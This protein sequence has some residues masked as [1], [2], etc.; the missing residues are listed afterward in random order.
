M[1]YDN[2]LADRIRAHVPAGSEVAEIAMFGG[3]CWTLNGHM[4]AGV[5]GSALLVPVGR[6][7]M[8]DALARGAHEMRM[9]QHIMSGFVGV[10]DPDDVHID[11]WLTESVARAANLPPKQKK[12][13]KPKAGAPG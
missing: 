7:G 2:G 12:P 6:D 5:L 13:K 1:A 11:E 9:G 10:D 8:A 3:V 4:F